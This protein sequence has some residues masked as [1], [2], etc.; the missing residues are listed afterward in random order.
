AVAGGTPERVAVGGQNAQDPSISRQGN[1]LSY[2]ERFIVNCLYR[3]SASSTANGETAPVKLLSSTRRDMNPELSPDGKR[4]AFHTTRSGSREIWVCDSDGANL[5]QLT[6]F[7]GPITHNPSWSPDGRQLVFDSR[8]EDHAA[9]F[10]INAAGGQ[11][12]QLT[13]GTFNSVLPS[14]SRDCQWIY[15]ASNQG[16]AW[17]VWKTSPSGGTAIQVT[18]KGGY[19]A[20]ESSDGQFLYYTKYGFNNDGLFRQ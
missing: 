3:I 16:G 13:T 18:K 11:P 17:Q 7:G 12:R 15:F 5:V 19:E 4:I 1:R 14:W 6:N 9:I 20:S 8:P 2:T 10:L